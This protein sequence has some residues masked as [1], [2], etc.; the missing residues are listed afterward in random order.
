MTKK[1]VGAVVIILG[2]ALGIVYFVRN[3]MGDVLSELSKSKCP[4]VFSPIMAAEPYYKG[5]IF[6]AHLHLPVVSKYVSDIAY[7]VGIPYPMWDE[8][9]S[10]EYLQCLFSSEGTSRAYGFH[11]LTKYS[12]TTEVKKAKEIEKL[13]PG[14]IVHFLMPVIINPTL[15]TDISAVRKV[16]EDNPNFFRGLGELKMHDGKDPDD[17]YVLGLLDLARESKL[18]VMMHPFNNHLADIEKIVRQYSDVTFLLHGI[19]YATD[20]G[21]GGDERDNSV[22]L[23]KLLMNNDNV[24]YSIDG[25]LP[26]HGWKREHL[27]KTV[28]KEETLPYAKSHFYSSLEQDVARYKNLIEMYPDRFLRGTDRQH[29]PHFDKE[30]S[31][32]LDEYTRALIGRLAPSVQEKFAHKNAEA[33]LKR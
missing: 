2:V 22:W 30:V 32:L 18:I 23:K 8:E 14:M 5:E 11:L 21:K 9:L 6:D 7:K 29:R 28:P 12:V 33:L 3:D 1:I 10:P 15:D 4:R 13:Y 16:L 20:F 17:P 25:G 24:Y 26:I 19:A 27:G 31:T